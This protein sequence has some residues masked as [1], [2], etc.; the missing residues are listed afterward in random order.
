MNFEAEHAPDAPAT[1]SSSRCKV[2]IAVPFYKNEA[3]VDSLV[4]SLIA[5][6]ADIVA[7]GGEV[8]LIDDS[9]GYQPLAEA[10]AR[11]LP[12][13][14][15]LFP[16]RMLPNKSNLGF[17]KTMNLAM[18]EAIDRKVD[19]LLLNSDTIVY[20]GAFTEMVRVAKLDSMI[21]FVN[22]RSDNATLATLPVRDRSSQGAAEFDM[23]PYAALAARLPEFSFVPTA[24]GFCMLIRWPILAE[25]GGFDEIF[26]Q[27]YNEEND[28]V[29]R[30]GRCGYR[31]VMAN[32]A[33]VKHDGE[34]SF[35]T[36]KISKSKLEPVNRAILDRRFPEYAAFTSAYFSS[37][38]RT[39]EQLLATLVP[40]ADGRL[41]L[42]FD[43]S[44][45]TPIHNGT[46]QAGKQ[47]L[48][49]ALEIWRARFN[50]HILC[51]PDVYAFHGFDKLGVP[52]C[53]PH[54]PEKFAVI[55]REGQPYDWSTIQRLFLKG[56][57]IGIYMLD[58][59]S[60]DCTQLTSQSLF[61]FWQFAL[62]HID[63]LVTPSQQSMD[64][65]DHRFDI[66]ARVT[67]LRSY[68]SLELADYRLPA[69][70]SDAAPP[71]VR[72]LVI[73]NHFPHKY[74]P[75]TVNAL[76]GAFPERTIV[77]L[78]QI[79]S[80]AGTPF[81]PYGL[82]DL[83]LAANIE[84]VGV[85]MLSDRDFAA[86]Y[87]NAA[88]LVF[89]SHYEGFGFPLLNALAAR[90]PVFVR[91]L[92]VFEELWES[93]DRNPNIHFYGSTA[94]LVAQLRRVPAWIEVASA[95]AVD[96]GA[97]R[98]AWEI[99]KGLET[100]LD[101]VDYRDVVGRVRALQILDDPTNRSAPS[102]RDVALS[103]DLPDAAARYLALRIEAVARRL[104]RV[105][106]I[107]WLSRAL[108]RVLR[109]GVRL[110]RRLRGGA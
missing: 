37:P 1:S 22:P 95:P 63:L 28:L 54:G 58:T 42:A 109:L 62:A 110:Q 14:Q 60:I 64:Q 100:A 70:V 17:V 74:L 56:A 21:G 76:A 83:D 4:G 3:L 6:A 68:H 35:G 92:P 48:I 65:L 81:N 101:H 34:R 27:G 98:S 23:R 2:L 55:F 11:V 9:P 105:P 43:F 91:R 106:L 87:A 96:N 86:F 7:I 67:R 13:A 61:N 108:F 45:F 47:L 103:G 59:I 24:V 26:G 75:Q 44:S 93:Q 94:D 32:R 50:I 5:C 97:A 25:F 39:A 107:Y 80:D 90:R 41:D 88:V 102:L 8:L 72:L 19:L 89:P 79:R 52:R 20:P 51:S 85:G 82:Q 33:F 36:A 18:R 16:C 104:L 53:D 31:A 84:G 71:D 49:S 66:P 12:R 73:G 15:A 10:L 30:A 38:E 78:G 46:F 40:D 57:V 29:M 77:A 99:L 69:D